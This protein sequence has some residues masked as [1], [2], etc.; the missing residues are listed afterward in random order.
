MSNFLFNRL[1]LARCLLL[2]GAMMAAPLSVAAQ[3]SLDEAAV[4]RLRESMTYLSGLQQFGLDSRT[5][6]E[7]V[8]LSGQKI[9]L[10]DSSMAIVQRPN[11]L[12]AVRQNALTNQKFI[13]DGSTLALVDEAAGYHAVVDAPAT[14]EGML[15]F[16]RES[17]DI[18]APAGDVIY[19]NAFDHLMQ[20]VYSGLVVGPAVIEGALCDQLAFS[21]PGTDWQIWIQQ[22]E[23]PLPRKMVITS[24]DIVNAP[25]FTVVIEKWDLEPEVSA[26]RFLFKP[27][28]GS[29]AVEFIPL[30]TAGPR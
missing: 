16:A 21:A 11:K 30:D 26:D 1:S 10:D 6:I 19:N 24:R 4:E 28:E 7:V 17:L 20:D 27:P 2:T 25:Q 14:L 22:G 3:P 12:Y 9:L 23:Q 13:Y 29:I 15:D 5:S 8:L 18:V